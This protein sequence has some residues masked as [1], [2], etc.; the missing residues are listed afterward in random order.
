MA[1]PPRDKSFEGL[2]KDIVFR[3]AR[4]ERRL[5]GGGIGVGSADPSSA[6]RLSVQL[7]PTTAVAANAVVPFSTKIENFGGWVISGGEFTCK[8]AG[9]YL[10]TCQVRQS[11]AVTGGLALQV[12]GVIVA[13][14]LSTTALA[15]TG[16]TITV[17]LTLAVDDVLRVV[18][19]A[20][21][22]TSQ[23]G[24]NTGLGSSVLQVERLN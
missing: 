15:N 12:N 8:A 10:I 7:P 6:S 3:L 21:A 2:L 1:S 9:R 19:G 16:W 18:N 4:V 22:F 24:N 14:S 23:S 17:L 5:S 11:T 20:V 13:Y